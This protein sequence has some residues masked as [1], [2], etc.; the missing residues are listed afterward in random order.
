MNLSKRQVGITFFEL[1]V[2]LI[3][4]AILMS[5]AVPSFSNLFDKNRVKGA[6]EQLSGQI[7]FARSEAISRNIDV[8]VDV[9]GG[10]NWCVG[11][12]D[13]DDACDCKTDGACTVNGV[14]SVTDGSDFNGVSIT[15][16]DDD[17]T[18][19]GTRG[20]PTGGAVVN[21]SFES[22]KGKELGVTVNAIGRVS[23]CS[24]SGSGNL[25]EY[26]ECSP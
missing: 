3:V 6:A 26:P 18:F 22:D 1:M 10:D 25:W 4:A 12:D 16:G 21:F 13:S 19:E 11:L 24:P 20:L 15:T 8:V 17:V 14:E 9:T 7:Q 23:L 2:T 5:I